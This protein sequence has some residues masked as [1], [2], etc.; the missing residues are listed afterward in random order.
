MKRWQDNP[1]RR[2][3]DDH[4]G[5]GETSG[6]DERLPT[7][8]RVMRGD[9]LRTE[10]SE[11]FGG[12]IPLGGGITI[13]KFRLSDGVEVWSNRRGTRDD[14]IESFPDESCRAIFSEGG[15]RFVTF[16][17]PVLTKSHSNGVRWTDN[18]T[19]SLRGTRTRESEG[20]DCTSRHGVTDFGTI[21]YRSLGVNFAF[22]HL[23]LYW[24]CGTIDAEPTNKKVVVA[25]D[26]TTLAEE[27]VCELYQCIT[28]VLVQERSYF[29][30]LVA[31]PDGVIVHRTDIALE[32]TQDPTHAGTSYGLFELVNSSGSVVATKTYAQNAASTGF[33]N[34]HGV[35]GTSLRQFLTC[36][37]AF[38]DGKIRFVSLPFNTADDRVHLETT[39]TLLELDTAVALNGYGDDPSLSH[40]FNDEYE[41][42][43]TTGYPLTGIIVM[44]RTDGTGCVVVPGGEPS[45]VIHPTGWNHFAP[46][47]N[48]TLV[49]GLDATLDYTTDQGVRLSAI[50]DDAGNDFHFANYTQTASALGPMLTKT[51]DGVFQWQT[52]YYVVPSINVHYHWF[53]TNPVKILTSG[54]V[55]YMIGEQ[56]GEWFDPGTGYET[57]N[58]HAEVAAVSAADGSLLW[59]ARHSSDGNSEKLLDG[60]IVGDYLYVCGEASTYEP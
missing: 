25:Y 42:G 13:R 56:N 14:F 54:G 23:G 18:G 24:T 37:R 10:T 1:R 28:P 20:Y 49:Y 17:T 46:A 39:D 11:D 41:L 36:P 22:E 27:F 29:L 45:G 16:G 58:S 53:P 47:V 48:N 44:A 19:S 2:T 7:D 35:W 8:R 3:P 4:G 32:D 59:T 15:D 21:G 52:H 31:V 50:R 51:T 60:V 5:G 55:H 38:T 12:G 30:Q 33:D 43:G 40:S 34:T 26:A 57:I 9:G 6:P